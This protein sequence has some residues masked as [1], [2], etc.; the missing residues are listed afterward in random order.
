MPEENEEEDPLRFR[1]CEE[2]NV[3]AVDVAADIFFRRFT[4][5]SVKPRV[6]SLETECPL[7]PV[8]AADSEAHQIVPFRASG[9]FRYNLARHRQPKFF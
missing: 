1:I 2:T 9:P 3:V 8:M 7:C 5:P 6:F 4:G